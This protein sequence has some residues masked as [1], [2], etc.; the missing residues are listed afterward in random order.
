MIFEIMKYC[1]NFFPVS[2]HSGTFTIEGG[3]IDCPFLAEGQYFLIENSVFNDGVY[4]YPTTEL[5]DE[6]FTG[7]VTALRIPS[8]FLELCE[9]VKAWQEKNGDI[10]SANMS[11]YQ[12]ESFGGYSYSKLATQD[13]STVM[14]WQQ[15]FKDRLKI[16][17]KK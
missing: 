10:S 2:Y 1:R 7:T 5:T 11:P 3:F 8:A 9:D 13:A 14:S 15:A 4:T 17:R 16:W 6:T 12:S